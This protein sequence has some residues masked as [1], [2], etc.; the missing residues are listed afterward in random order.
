MFH[1]SEVEMFQYRL[2][3]YSC[4]E[5][6]ELIPKS[7]P[8]CFA[9]GRHFCTPECYR[10]YLDQKEEDIRWEEAMTFSAVPGED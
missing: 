5:C 3:Q 7:Q 4:D 6:Q 8:V 10:E 1:V 9:D 2:Q